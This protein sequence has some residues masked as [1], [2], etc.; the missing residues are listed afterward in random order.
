MIQIIKVNIELSEELFMDLQKYKIVEEIDSI[1]NTIIKILKENQA[2]Q[3][4]LNY[5]EAMIS[6]LN[7]L[8]TG[9]SFTVLDLLPEKE[10]NY[11]LFFLIEVENMFTLYLDSMDKN[12]NYYFLFFCQ[13]T[14][15]S[16]FIK[17]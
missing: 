8:K 3:N 12:E 15:L 2:K 7:N 9:T 13:K 5:L 16:T 6:V 4:I 11:D 1:E 17:Y 10:S 14:F